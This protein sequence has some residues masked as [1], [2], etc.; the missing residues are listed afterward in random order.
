VVQRGMDAFRL[1]GIFARNGE[2][3]IISCKWKQGKK[4]ISADQDVYE[5]VADHIGKYAA[6]MIAPDDL[7]LVNEGSELR[8]KWVDGILSQVDRTYLDALLQYQR[9]L[10]QPN[11]WLKQQ[12][13]N[14]DPN[15]IALDFYDEQL[16]RTG[17]YSFQQRLQFRERF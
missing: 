13:S 16:W 11:A 17:T 1:D 2:Q 6:V 5:R 14:P 8:R 10:L 12:Y 9:V 4:E 7:A 3:E 15:R